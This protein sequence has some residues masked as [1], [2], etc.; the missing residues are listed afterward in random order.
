VVLSFC[1]LIK[2]KDNFTSHIVVIVIVV[3]VAAAADDD[4]DVVLFLFDETSV[5]FLAMVSPLPAFRATEFLRGEKFSTHAQP[6]N[7]KAL[8]FNRFLYTHTISLC[9]EVTRHDTNIRFP[10][11]ISRYIRETFV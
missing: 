4:D 8:H 3:V 11:L 5:H 9:I 7:W 2:Q 1:Y 10:L 6:Q